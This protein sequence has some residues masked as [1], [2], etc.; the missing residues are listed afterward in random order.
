MLSLLKKGSCKPTFTGFG[1]LRQHLNE[2][3]P[4]KQRD[5]LSDVPR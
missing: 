1:V 4:Q 5:T 3:N 2:V